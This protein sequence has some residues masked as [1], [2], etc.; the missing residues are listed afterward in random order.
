MATEQSHFRKEQREG[1]VVI[2]VTTPRLIDQDVIQVLERN[3]IPVLRQGKRLVVALDL[4]HLE[5][6]SSNGA[7]LI[8]LCKQSVVQNG[9]SLVVSGLRPAVLELFSLMRIDRIVR[10]FGDLED[11]AAAVA[12]GENLEPEVQ[13]ASKPA[14]A[15]TPALSVESSAMLKRP[16][17][18]GSAVHYIN[19]PTLKRIIRMWTRLPEETREQI[20]QLAEAH[21][22][23]S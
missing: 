4:S 13:R 16:V 9:G 5:Y 19:D 17:H 18:T 1:L 2:T 21:A 10:F 7:G 23:P 11:V 6:L 3:L 22:V 14:P 8:M 20:R 12:A 15:S